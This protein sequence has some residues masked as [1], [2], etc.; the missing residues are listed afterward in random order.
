VAVPTWLLCCGW[1]ALFGA[2]PAPGLPCPVPLF[3]AD[4]LESP[5][6]AGDEPLFEPTCEGFDS[7]PPPAGVADVPPGL[8]ELPEP[9]ATGSC[10]VGEACPVAVGTGFEYWTS[11]E[12]A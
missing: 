5:P 4:A 9:V 7:D 8:P 3:G 2:E 12:S 10:C 1:A 6:F 11:L